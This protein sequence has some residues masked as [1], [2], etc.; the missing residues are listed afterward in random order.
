MGKA[1]NLADLLSSTGDVRT[2]ALDNAALA[3]MS[4]ISSLPAGVVTQ[5]KG[6]T[7][8]TG[9]QGPQGAT[10]AIGPQGPQGDT[11]P[12]GPIG[13]TGPQGA[14]GATG[15]QGAT[16]AQGPVGATFSFAG[17]VLTITS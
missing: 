14:T 6:D 11:G 5:L 9:P 13:N 4:N 7:G 15:P 8:A 1:R 16:G 10:G 2:D 3:D 17:G 12:Q